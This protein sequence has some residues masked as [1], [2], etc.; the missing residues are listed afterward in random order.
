MFQLEQNENRPFKDNVKSNKMAAP[1][2]KNQADNTVSQIEPELLKAASEQIQKVKDFFN[3]AHPPKKRARH[4]TFEEERKAS[5][6]SP[7]QLISLED[8]IR[9]SSAAIKK[10]KAFMT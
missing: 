10:A 6:L 1:L 9:R 3:D 7:K 8:L 5:K 2:S 4:A